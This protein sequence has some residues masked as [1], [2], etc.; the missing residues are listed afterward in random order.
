MKARTGVISTYNEDLGYGFIRESGSGIGNRKLVSW[1][2]H[3]NECNCIPEKG[4]NVQFDIREGRK[5]PM[6]VDV[7]IFVYPAAGLDA[8]A[9]KAGA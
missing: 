4:L 1:Y 7:S 5:G 2:F 6:A 3:V 8:L 9:G